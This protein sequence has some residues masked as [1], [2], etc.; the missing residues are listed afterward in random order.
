M[1]D[2]SEGLGWVR[3]KKNLPLGGEQE[4]ERAANTPYAEEQKED[5][6]GARLS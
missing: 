4:L 1:L 2:G 5:R 6:G 3:R